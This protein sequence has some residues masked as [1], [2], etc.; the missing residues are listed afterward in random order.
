MLVIPISVPE[1]TKYIFI[2][3]LKPKFICTLA[4]QIQSILNET[5]SY[6]EFFD[7]VFWECVRYINVSNGNIL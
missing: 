7:C 4:I 3:F 2:H 5:S 1:G 6:L